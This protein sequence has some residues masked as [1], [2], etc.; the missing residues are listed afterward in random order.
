MQRIDEKIFFCNLFYFEIK[1]YIYI[2][3][4]KYK[5]KVDKLNQ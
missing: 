5:K 3:L 4:K 1:S 2:K